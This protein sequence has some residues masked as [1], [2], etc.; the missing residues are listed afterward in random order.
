MELTLQELEQRRSRFIALMNQSF[1]GWDTAVILENVNQYYF[2]G[3]MQNGILLI[4]KEG[5][6]LYGV[7]RSYE[8]ARAESPLTDI[9]PITSYRDIAEKN[10]GK[11]GNVC[12]EGDTAT[13]AVLERLRKN[14]AIGSIHFLDPV[15]RKVRSVKSPYEIYWLKRSG[16][17]HRALLEERVPAL[18]REGMTEADLM[19]EILRQLYAMG[20]HGIPRFHQS[21][22]ELTAGQIGFGTNALIP[23]SFDGPGGGLGSSPA[24][25]LAEGGGRKLKPGD[26]VFADV[27]FGLRGYF[28]D[29]T[30]AYLFGASVPEELAEA[31]QFCLDLLAKTAARLKPGEIPSQ[32]YRDITE[33]LSEKEQDCF[34]G[35]DNQHRV[36]FLGHGTGLNIDEFPVIARGF[37]EPLE[38]NMVVA[39]EPKKGVPGAGMAGVEETFVVTP[40]GGQCLT[41]GGRGLIRVG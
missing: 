19:G 11:L 9:M 25:L 30:Q 40:R 27:A 21:Q 14:F 16:E 28:T 20:Y 3:T 39:L 26:L 36:K 34:M 41:G 37:D 29:K 7:R 22:V 24:N 1:P 6:C 15:I 8:R 4:Y 23:S 5:N 12:L 33:G 2:T 18:L 13:L 35:V 38:E 17:Q 10:G 32:I 31:Q